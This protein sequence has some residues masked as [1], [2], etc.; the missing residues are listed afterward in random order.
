MKRPQIMLNIKRSEENPILVPISENAWEAEAVFNGCP[1]FFNKEIYFL[2]RALSLPQKIN[3]VEMQVSSIGCALSAD[4]AHFKNR[5]QFIKPEQEWEKFGCEDPRVT[6]L[7]GKFYI[8]YTALSKYPFGSEGIKVGLA[9][10][11][12][13]KSIEAKYQVTPFNAK[14]M[15]L[16]P[17][18][19]NGKMAAVLTVNTDSPPA[20]IGI[21]YFDSEEQ[22]WSRGYWENWYTSLKENTLNLKRTPNDHIEVGAPPIKTKYGWL[23]FYSYIQNYFSPPATFGVEAALLDLKNPLKILATTRQPLLVPKE[24]YEK[25]GKAPNIVFPSG[26]FLKG[27]KI[28]LYY[29]AADTVCCLAVLKLNDL[30]EEIFSG[31]DI[32]I[33]LKRSS[34]NPV[35]KPMPEHSWEAKAVF[36]TGVIYLDKKVHLIY[37]A[38]SQDNT[39]VLGY[40]SSVDGFV[41][42]E[43]LKEPIYV[44]RLDFEQKKIAAGNSGC[45]DPRLTEIKDKIYMCYTAFDGQN[46]PRVALTSILTADFV[47][48][49]WN[50]ALPILISSPETMDKNAAIFPKKI[51]GKYAILHRP[52]V[53]IWLDFVDSL[54]FDGK[55]WIKGKIIMDPRSGGNDSRKIGISGPPIE[56]RLGWLL[57][58]HDISKKDPPTYRL[59]A[60]LL[61][62]DNPSR[63]IIRTKNPIIEPEMPYEK[64][65]QVPNVVFSCGS[66]VINNRLFVYYGGA[67]KVIGVAT[68]DIAEILEKLKIES[69]A[70][71]KLTK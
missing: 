67:D 2:Y 31:G 35:L 62:L 15:A 8:F 14:A 64:E 70:R 30:I 59:R 3:G 10:T 48:K 42:D 19:I 37:R 33:K 54:D 39:S 34:G 47:R 66:A 23:L 55:T 41:I 65:G 60:A 52:G 20:D 36:N 57:L 68:I 45:E 44:P 11:K 51:N 7:N 40:A 16:F 25:Y 1:V 50:W 26:A 53:S 43:R 5:R 17:E 18:K 63:V 71:K 32:F 13:F 46:P 69:G 12:D 21:I 9:I 4:G 49:K 24:E 61:D 27:G 22:I 38:M 58:Y 6:K 29:G 28:Y 56:T